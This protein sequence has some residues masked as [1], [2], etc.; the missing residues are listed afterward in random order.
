MP[1]TYLWR[2]DLSP[3]GCAAAPY[4]YPDTAQIAGFRGASH[5]SG[6]KSPRHKDSS[7]RP[8]GSHSRSK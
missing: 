4:K 5:P 3:L 1:D 2:G 8:I 6:D 7:V